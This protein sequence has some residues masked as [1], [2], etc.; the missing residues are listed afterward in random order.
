MGVVSSCCKS[1]EE[2]HELPTRGGGGPQSGDRP[3]EF[4]RA[5]ESHFS[6]RPKTTPQDSAFDNRGGGLLQSQ[7]YEASFP[8]RSPRNI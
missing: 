8:R 5:V 6:N 2:I 3:T 1:V 7:Y 4:S